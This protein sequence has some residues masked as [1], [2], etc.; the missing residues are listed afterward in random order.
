[1]VQSVFGEEDV[2]IVFFNADGGHEDACVE[3]TQGE[4]YV[5]RFE[6]KKHVNETNEIR[7]ELRVK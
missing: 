2:G 5:E 6:A 7:K 4:Y 3:L 1:M